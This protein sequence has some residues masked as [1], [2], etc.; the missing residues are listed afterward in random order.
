MSKKGEADGGEDPADAADSVSGVNASVVAV[1]DCNKTSP[2]VPRQARTRSLRG[3]HWLLEADQMLICGMRIGGG[4]R[5]CATF[6]KFSATR[7]AGALVWVRSIVLIPMCPVVAH[8]PTV[9]QNE[10]TS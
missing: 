4:V 1:A 6:Q 3:A 2:K 10:A 9:L 8:S 5:L 7:G